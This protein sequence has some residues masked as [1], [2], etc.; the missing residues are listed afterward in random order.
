MFSEYYCQQDHMLQM[1]WLGIY[2]VTQ[3]MLGVSSESLFCTDN[4]LCGKYNGAE[5]PSSMFIMRYKKNVLNLKWKLLRCYYS[6]FISICGLS[7]VALFFGSAVFV[8]QSWNRAGY[9]FRKR[10]DS[11]SY[12][13][14]YLHLPEE[15]QNRVRSYY[16][17]LWYNQRGLTE[18]LSLLQDEGMSLPLRQQIAI[19]TYKDLLTKIPLFA[20]AND[21]MLGLVSLQLQMIVYMPNDVIITQGE[22]GRELF[23]VSKGEVRVQKLDENHP[24]VRLKDGS[25]FGEIALLMEVERTRTVV[26]ATICELCIL[27]KGLF[28]HILGEFPQFAH[29]MKR[30]VISR[31]QEQEKGKEEVRKMIAQVADQKIEERKKHWQK[32]RRMIPLLTMHKQP[33]LPSTFKRQGSGNT[34]R[35]TRRLSNLLRPDKNGDSTPVTPGV[36]SDAAVADLTRRLTA[37]EAELRKARSSRSI[38]E[39][40]SVAGSEEGSSENIESLQRDDTEGEDNEGGD[41]Q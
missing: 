17:Y 21:K 6:V 27:E 30:L 20:N 38:H 10:M 12:E 16:D 9:K 23:I 5:V 19:F 15:M 33:T 22:F 26:A 3:S 11:I 35:S 14:D 25:F 29:E 37:M 24:A 40:E 18:K 7:I 32:A 34:L 8:V 2:Y 36:N 1:Y 41:K 31:T 13:M 39:L 4:P 28:D